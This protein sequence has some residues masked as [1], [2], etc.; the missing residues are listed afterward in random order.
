VAAGTS[1]TATP[2]KPSG[3]P[4][5]DRWRQA[6]YIYLHS[7]TYPRDAFKQVERE[8]TAHQPRDSYRGCPATCHVC[9]SDVAREWHDDLRR[10]GFY[11]VPFQHGRAEGLVMSF[12][13]RCSKGD[14]LPT[15]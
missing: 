6:G 5:E 9:Q 8:S 4:G 1:T 2:T 11:Q 3:R 13:A 12:R 15:A 14:A 10:S 7:M